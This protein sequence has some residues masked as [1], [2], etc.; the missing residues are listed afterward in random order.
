LTLLSIFLL[1]ATGLTA[2][3]LVSGA[4]L[5]LSALLAGRLPQGY[6]TRGLGSGRGRTA[7]LA[8][9][10]LLLGVAALSHLGTGWALERWPY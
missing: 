1:L 2:F 10:A 4:A 6:L 9:G 3:S 7:A 5:L 8:L